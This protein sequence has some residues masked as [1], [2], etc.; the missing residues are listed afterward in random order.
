MATSTTKSVGSAGQAA[1]RAVGGA[2]NRAGDVAT[3]AASRTREGAED[4]WAEAKHEAGKPSGRD[5]A[6]YA[7]LAATA[8]LG[9]VELPLA[10]AG[11]LAYA[12][13]RRRR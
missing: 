9:V 5:A 4:I 1:G 8:V 13:I 10:A 12:L 2:L 7:G 3:S 6:V 11:G